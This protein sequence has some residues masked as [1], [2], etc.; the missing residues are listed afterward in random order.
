MA[1][2]VAPRYM[3]AKYVIGNCGQLGSHKATTSPFFTPKSFNYV[4]QRGE[5]VNLSFEI[6][7]SGNECKE[8]ELSPYLRLIMFTFFHNIFYI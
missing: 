3:A 4:Y 7:N 1:V 6:W 8:N 2:I 5:I